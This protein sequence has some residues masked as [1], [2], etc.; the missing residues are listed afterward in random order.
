M[1]IK[2]DKVLVEN[3]ADFTFVCR[4]IPFAI[5]CSELHQGGMNL[6]DLDLVNK[7]KIPVRNIRVTRMSLLGHD[8]R[9][10]GR[11]KQTVQC[12]VNGRP[13]G[14][15]HLEG[16]VVRDLY[17]LLNVDCLA[18]FKTHER[19]MGRKPPDP[20]DEGYESTEDIPT[21]GGDEDASDDKK[22][23]KE[24]SINN[25][26]KTLEEEVPPDPPD[27]GNPSTEPR[28]TLRAFQH[29]EWPNFHVFETVDKDD[30]EDIDSAKLQKMSDDLYA[31]YVKNGPGPTDLL[32]ARMNSMQDEDEDED[33]DNKHCGLCFRDGKPIKVVSNHDE[34][35]PTCPTL[36]P[37]EKLRRHGPYWKQ[38][39]EMIFK[40][41]FNKEVGRE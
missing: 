28:A 34:G 21:L 39:A 41:R 2:T 12:V 36:T 35:C 3:G 1:A 7:M 22:E 32:V 13:Q 26:D 8:V 40:T 9:A 10:V 4:K 27:L 38:Q 16:K 23:G 11:I 19:L 33:E 14:N 18:S 20:S 17:A 30:D 31:D 6:I 5:S 29:P 15:I 25:E 37:S 24:D